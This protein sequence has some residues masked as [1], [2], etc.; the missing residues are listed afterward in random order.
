MIPLRVLIVLLYFV[1]TVQ[2]VYGGLI[3]PE[4]KDTKQDDLVILNDAEKQKIVFSNWNTQ[5]NE[6]SKDPATMW[7]ASK[8][9]KL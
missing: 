9:G 5:R 3:K 8:L 6:D 2:S 1:F 7:F 4:D